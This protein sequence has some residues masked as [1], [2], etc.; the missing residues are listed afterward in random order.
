MQ[1][2]AA[3]D[4]WNDGDRRERKRR[5]FFALWPDDETRAAVIGA[6]RT[7]VERAPGRTTPD[8]NLHLTLAFLGDVGEAEFARLQQISAPLSGGFQL[9]ID[10]LEFRRRPRLLWAV[11][12]AVPA[13]LLGLESWLWGRLGDLGIQRE[14]RTYRPH[15]TLARRV[16]YGGGELTPVRWPVREFVLVES[17]LGPPHSTYTVVKSWPLR[18]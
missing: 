9:A 11:P 15:M 12:G 7:L 2:V 1:A 16:D 8:E 5:L 6:T 17:L 3:A 4:F 13:A 10:T 18:S 14:R